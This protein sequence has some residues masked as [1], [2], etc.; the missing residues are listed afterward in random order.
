MFFDCEDGVEDSVGGIGAYGRKKETGAYHHDDARVRV[1]MTGLDIALL[2]SNDTLNGSS[3]CRNASHVGV[4]MRRMS[5]TFHCAEGWMQSVTEVGSFIADFVDRNAGGCRRVAVVEVVGEADACPCL[6]MTCSNSGGVDPH[7]ETNSVD[8]ADNIAVDLQCLPVVAVVDARLAGLLSEFVTQVLPQARQV[9]PVVASDES[10]GNG[11]SMG[12][13]SSS[14]VR[15]RIIRAVVAVPKL[16]LRL[17][18][19][20]NACSSAAHAALITSVRNGT[21]PVGWAPREA[22]EELSPALVL[23]IE[24]ATVAVAVGGPKIPTATLECTRI[25]CQMLLVCSDGNRGDGG[26]DLVGLYFLEASRV[27]TPL[28]V[29]YGLADDMRKAGNLGAARPGDADL[30]FLHTWEPNDG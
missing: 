2:L 12:V 5:Q 16:T 20:P 15:N 22:P 13:A 21:S 27:D 23:E 9:P 25:A 6:Q 1:R 11:R 19:D 30:K 3:T 28:K 10:G 24:S 4:Q 26:G 7:P 18:A 8:G 14:K 17:P 29:E